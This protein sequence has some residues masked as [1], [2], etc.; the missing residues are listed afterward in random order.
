MWA[1][2]F[3]HTAGTQR[4]IDKT[5]NPRTYN[6][7]VR[8]GVTPTTKD[9]FITLSTCQ[10]TGDGRLLLVGLLIDDTLTK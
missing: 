6:Q 1:Y 5:L 9:R 3:E 2:D 8:E 10:N 4:F 7:Q